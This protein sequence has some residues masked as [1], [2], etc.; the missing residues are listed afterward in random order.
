MQNTIQEYLILLK[1]RSQLKL[2]IDND[3]IK[4]IITELFESPYLFNIIPVE[5]LG[6]AYEQFLGKVIRL[7]KSHNAK[8]DLKPEVRKAGEFIIHLNTSLIT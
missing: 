1:L 8:I 6:I 5:I 4:E 2:K 3:T 7:T